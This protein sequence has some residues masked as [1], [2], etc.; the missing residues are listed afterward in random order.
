MVNLIINQT[1]F[2]ISHPLF[3]FP[4]RGEKI[5]DQYLNSRGVACNAPTNN[6]S[7]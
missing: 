4:P 7:K 5:T 6:N 2:R 1:D 3:D